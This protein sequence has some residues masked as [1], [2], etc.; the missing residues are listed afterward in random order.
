MM[1]N[2]CVLRDFIVVV[3]SKNEKKIINVVIFF[4]NENNI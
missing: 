2:N 3:G 4:L 1:Y